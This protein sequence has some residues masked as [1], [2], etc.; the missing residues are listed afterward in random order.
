VVGGFGFP[1]TVGLDGLLFGGVLGG[2]V[3]E[4]PCCAWGL[5]AERMDECIAG[6]VADQGIDHVG[7]GDV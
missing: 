6:H 4:I 7:V 5:V 1:I 2:D 3:Q